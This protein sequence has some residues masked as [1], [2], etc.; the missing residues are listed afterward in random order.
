MAEILA[1]AGAALDVVDFLN[2]GVEGLGHLLVHRQRVVALDEVGLPAASQEEVLQLLV[3]HAA[4]HCG[5]A[6]FVAV[7]V[8]NRQH[9][10]VA[11]GVQEL[12]ALPAGGQGAGLGLAV[13]DGDRGDQVGV[14]KH[15]AEGVAME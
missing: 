5:I 1:G 3:G 11:H 14:I 7:Q 12:V 10:A 2:H 15:R 8:Q 6:D 9:G 13:A 4:E